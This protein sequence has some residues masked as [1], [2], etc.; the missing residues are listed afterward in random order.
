M[1]THGSKLIGQFGQANMAIQG[2]IKVINYYFWSNVSQKVIII[3]NTLKIGP[4]DFW[5]F[6]I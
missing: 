4:W 1:P 2:V 5:V 6:R 3:E